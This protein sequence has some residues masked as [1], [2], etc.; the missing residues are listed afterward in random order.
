MPWKLSTN[1]LDSLDS[2]QT[3]TLTFMDSTHFV[4]SMKLSQF[5]ETFQVESPK[6][7]WSYEHFKSESEIHET[8][9]FP[10]INA[11]HSSID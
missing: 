10:P 6:G 8:E 2:L 4:P 5:C 3:E 1:L 7:C 11:F 9:N